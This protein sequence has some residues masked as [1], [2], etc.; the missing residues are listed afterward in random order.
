MRAIPGGAVSLPPP[1]DAL[2]E[3]ARTSERQGR[4]EVARRRYEAVLHR[5]DHS[6]Q[7]PT[8]AA[9]LRWIGRTYVDDADLDAA[10]DCFQAALAVA[11]ATGDLSGRANTINCIAAVF[12]RRGLL[13]RAETSYLRARAGAEAA[14]DAELVA[15]TEH[16]LGTIATIRG[17]LIGA[18]EHYRRSLETYRALGSSERIAALL[19]NLGMLYT[20]L[21]RWHEAGRTYAEALHIAGVIGD[22]STQIMVEV[23]RT[24]LWIARRDF[25]RARES[26]DAALELARQAGDERP[27]GDIYKHYG[28]IF[29]E[30]GKLRLADEHLA[31][32]ARFAEEREDMLLA[33][34]TA[35]E[36]AEVHRREERNR[37]TLQCLN[38]AHRLF[39][40]LRAQRDLADVDRRVA[41]LEQT[42]LEIV[43]R[44]SESIESK[45]RYTKGHCERVADYACALA[46]AAG[47]EESTLIWFRMGAL[48]HDVGKV[49]VPSEILNKPGRLTDE[50]R[51]I[52]ERHTVAG[53]E[54]LAGIEFPWDIR[55]MLRHHHERWDGTGYPDGLAGEEI[56]LAARVLCVADVYDAL[57]TRRS[58]RP[59]YPPE[60]ALELMGDEAG[61]MFDPDLFRRFK[62][63]WAAKEARAPR[64]TAP[65]L[66]TTQKRGR[67]Q[68][69]FAAVYRSAARA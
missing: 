57:T 61:H 7:G 16:N 46:R 48:L 27:L 18:L 20:D 3:E 49:V 4:R 40:E 51:R 34:E 42:Y 66:A 9:L 10:L 15:M 35:R 60:L 6:S 45:D 37:D 2:L 64:A 32:A 41:R 5:L 63:M 59:A 19:N 30:S 24:E 67:S 17:N 50:E 43:C 65:L 55:P 28:V 47:L 36:Q 29:R 53:V 68:A 52:M 58:Y 54:L 14:G 44:W 56:P 22:M 31:R 39:S 23:N 21:G 11:E 25:V 13:D 38:R 26:C 33:A 12:L 8:A 69:P 62:V 1:L